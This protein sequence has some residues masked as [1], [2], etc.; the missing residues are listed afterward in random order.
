M[1][2]L[3]LH[4][5]IPSSSHEHTLTSSAYSM[6]AKAAMYMHTRLQEWASGSWEFVLRG[7]R[8]SSSNETLRGK[9]F[10]LHFRCG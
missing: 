2:V 9:L 5:A 8:G 4:D 6:A 10:D 3:F 1:P 7:V